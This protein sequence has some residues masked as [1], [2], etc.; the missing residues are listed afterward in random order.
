M[1]PLR[2]VRSPGGVAGFQGE[3]KRG[4]L[5]VFQADGLVLPSEGVGTMVLG[6]RI[7]LHSVRIILN[8]FV[9]ALRISVVPLGVVTL[10]SYFMIGVSDGSF[11]DPMDFSVQ[12]SF[13]SIALPLLLYGFAACW[14]AIGWHR[15]VLLEEEPGPAWPRWH[16]GEFV[17]Y[18]WAVIR[19]F[20]TALIFGFVFSFLGQVVLAATGVGSSTLLVVFFAWAVLGGFLFTAISLVLPAAAVG[21]HIAI[22]QSW[23]ATFEKPLAVLVSVVLVTV[24]TSIPDLLA[25]TALAPVLSAPG[26]QICASWIGMMLGVSILTTLYGV[27]I[28]GR[29]IP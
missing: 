16:F 19:L 9:P 18:I 12:V 20:I 11:R 26:Y 14:V 6:W 3:D 15:Y 25:G 22:S 23:T 21:E 13:W 29:E 24:F 5:T 8:N 4:S 1:G 27:L 7:F 2:H 28:E 17:A 10:V